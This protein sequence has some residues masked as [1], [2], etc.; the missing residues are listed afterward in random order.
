MAK[1]KKNYEIGYGKPPRQNR[2]KTG[3]SGNP[4]GRPKGSKNLATI[5]NEVASA[6]VTVSENGRRR[7]V[8]KVEAIYC[9]LANTAL[10]GDLRAARDFLNFHRAAEVLQSLDEPDFV[11]HERDEAVKKSVLKRIHK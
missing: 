7:T 3:V 9:R 2:F 5:I 10:T 6:P 4:K 8:T 11:P 1:S